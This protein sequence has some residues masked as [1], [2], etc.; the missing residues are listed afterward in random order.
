MALNEETTK[1]QLITPKILEAGWDINKIIMEYPITA[2][3]IQV[4]DNLVHVGKPKRADYLL[5]YNSSLPLAVV[6]AKGKGEDPLDGKDQAYEYGN[7][8]RVPYAFTT[9]GEKWFE[10]NLKN[11]SSKEIFMFPS[12]QE[13][14]ERYKKEYNITPLVEKVLGVKDYYDPFKKKQARY[15]QRIAINSVCEAVAREQKRVLLVCATGTGK[16]FIASQIVE[17]LYNSGT[18]KKILYL[19]DR[20]ILADQPRNGDFAHFKDITDKIQSGKIDSAYNIYFGLYQQFTSEENKEKY[21]EY[22][23][24]YFDLIIIDECHRGSRKADSEWREIL[25][26]FGSA[27]HLGLTATPI[28]REDGS[29]YDY[30]GKPVYTYSLKQGIEDGFLAPYNVIRIMLDLDLKGLKLPPGSVDRYGNPIEGEFSSAAFD[31]TIVIEERRKLIAKYITEFLKSNPFMKTIVFCQ[32]EE[33][34]QGMKEE[35]IR[36]NSA[37]QQNSKNNNYIVRITGSDDFGKSQLDYFTDEDEK[38]PS[39]ATTSDMLST[40][41]DVTTCGLIAI[42]KN[43]ESMSLFKQIIGRGTRL[44]KDKNKYYFTIMDFRGATKLFSDPEFDGEPENIK[45]IES[46]GPK[47]SGGELPVIYDGGGPE[48]IPAEDEQPKKYYFSHPV[49]ITNEIIRTLD[50]D[51]KLI[52]ESITKFTRNNMLE[53]YRT[54]SDFIKYWTGEEKREAI[55]NEL[56]EKGIWI[57]ELRK[58]QNYMDMDEFDILCQIAYNQ[59][60]KTRKE[61]GEEAKKK[62]IYG[63]YSEECREII[64]ILID[65][66]CDYGIENIND[67]KILRTIGTPVEIIGKFGG[68]SKYLE[69]IKDIEKALYI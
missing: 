68:K 40:G 10:V 42:D 51:G 24:D 2:G 27:T 4:K 57:D 59:K 38:Y 48:P 54:M 14:Y 5:Y 20:N 58:D 21:K 6:E 18:C 17:K 26:Y 32:D 55:I 49:Y 30:F 16:T 52:T 19:A 60:P 36:Q 35:L 34:A 37:Y 64:D 28:N 33:H 13:L 44:N 22:D 25:E 65:K 1:L 7:K 69:A 41:V 3:R 9:N 46:E 8:L 62:I 45:E 53:Y 47:D 12:P 66:Y 29:N 63:K 43:I 50:K 56:G 23:K 15:Y 39:V 61:R 67:M 31:R 11:G